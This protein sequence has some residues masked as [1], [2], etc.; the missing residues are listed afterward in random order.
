[1]VECNLA[2]VDVASSN[3]VSRS[4]YKNG[5]HFLKTV[6]FC[7]ALITP[8][9]KKNRQPAQA[10][11]RFK[12]PGY[13]VRNR[14]LSV[15][16]SHHHSGWQLDPL[17]FLFLRLF[18]PL[19][20]IITILSLESE[21][22]IAENLILAGPVILVSPA[23][24]KSAQFRFTQGKTSQCDNLKNFIIAQVKGNFQLSEDNIVVEAVLRSRLLPLTLAANPGD[25]TIEEN[26][27]MLVIYMLEG[28]IIIPFEPVAETRPRHPAISC[29]KGRYHFVIFKIKYIAYT[30]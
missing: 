25:Q 30:P 16:A 8:H 13:P 9:F 18:D 1:M 4:I 29:R 20:Y 17:T 21:Q 28:R 3:L 26:C 27:K 23:P 24:E 7:L 2:K 22:E 6:F 5:L 19:E 14:G 12:I 10:D 15:L 11:Q